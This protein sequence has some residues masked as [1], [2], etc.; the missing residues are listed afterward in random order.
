MGERRVGACD[1]PHHD[2]FLWAQLGI[3][4]VHAFVQEVLLERG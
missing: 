1:P 4:N 2:A 3:I